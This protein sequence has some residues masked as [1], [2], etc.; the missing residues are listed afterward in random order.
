MLEEF[1]M[2]ANTTNFLMICVI[3]I[4]CAS[5]GM[6]TGGRDGFLRF[7]TTNGTCDLLATIGNTSCFTQNF[8]I[9]PFVVACLRQITF[10][11]GFAVVCIICFCP[12]SVFMITSCLDTGG[13]TIACCSAAGICC[14]AALGAN[15]I[16]PMRM[17]GLVTRAVAVIAATTTG[18]TASGV[19]RGTEVEIAD[20]SLSD[21]YTCAVIAGSAGVA[22]NSIEI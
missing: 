16:L 14:F 11:T 13:T 4:G 8:T 9:F 21:H 7:C 10:G 1:L 6:N 18:G 3:N 15:L 20:L 17:R 19:I 2:A 22:F 5:I 12:L